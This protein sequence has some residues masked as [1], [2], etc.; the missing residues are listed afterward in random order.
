MNVGWVGGDRA[1]Q[2]RETALRRKKLAARL[3]KSRSAAQGQL[4]LPGEPA[5]NLP[6]TERQGEFSLPVESAVPEK[7]ER[8]SAAADQLV[9]DHPSGER[10]EARV[11][12]IPK[13]A[14]SLDGSAA[15]IH[16]TYQLPPTPAWLKALGQ[17]QRLGLVKVAADIRNAAAMPAGSALVSL[18]WPDPPPSALL[19]WAVSHLGCDAGRDRPLRVLLVGAGRTD[20]RLLSDCMID[21][22]GARP[23]WIPDL[24]RSMNPMRDAMACAF[25]PGRL[26]PGAPDSLRVSSLVPVLHARSDSDRPWVERW[27]GFMQ[28]D[29]AF[30]RSDRG[31]Q[32]GYLRHDYGV[33]RSTRPFAFVLPQ[34]SRGSRR[35]VEIEAIPG[36]VDLVI[37]DYSATWLWPARIAEEVEQLFL[38]VAAAAGRAPV[39][40]FLVLVS[41]PRSR[42]AVLRTVRE[43]QENVRELQGDHASPGQR[44][45]A[46]K[47]YVGNRV[48]HQTSVDRTCIP[49]LRIHAAS[50]T[51]GAIQDEL[52]G[53][54]G[55]LKTSHPKTSEALRQAVTVLSAMATSLA[56]PMADT[57]EPEVMLTFVD[58]ARDARQA[59]QDEGPPA[60]M[61]AIDDALKRGVQAGTKLL[62]N[63]PARVALDEARAAAL[64]GRKVVFVAESD[65]EAKEAAL[66]A[67]EGLL[68]VSR[69]TPGEEIARY[70]PD[71]LVTACRG[72]DALRLLAEQPVPPT[73]VVMLLPP[74]EA[75]TVRRIG[76]LV[77]E[78]SD[79]SPAHGLCKQI[80]DGLPPV[81]SHLAT[82]AELTAGRPRRGRSVSNDGNRAGVRDGVSIRTEDGDIS[83]FASGATLITLVDGLP[84][85]KRAVDL[86]PGDAVIIVPEDVA[87]R[88]IRELGWNSEA[89]LLDVQVLRYKRQVQRWRQGPGAGMT[90][91]QIV[92]LMREADPTVTEPSEAA[93]R[94]WVSAGV[95]EEVAAPRATGNPQ[96]LAAFFKVI[97]LDDADRDFIHFGHHR[98][99]LQREGHLRSGLLERFLFDPYDAFVHH[100]IDRD[101]ARALRETALNSVRVVTWVGLPA[102]ETRQ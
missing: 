26:K 12:A 40:R 16:R 8:G 50:T 44:V 62:R 1:S 73:E 39:P 46:Q 41:D 7:E 59:M 57:E 36:G 102:E 13:V 100:G 11:T 34:V 91:R 49:R 45:S 69:R 87:G 48:G 94:Y 83:E 28:E 19:A 64:R 90:Y 80:V 22:T 53:F 70:V 56:P 93:V 43:L 25:L 98:G 15:T 79:L 81:F 33:A 78:S 61:M 67:P 101:R 63:S 29:R 42:L 51:E 35:T 5:A 14:R 97:G 27:T 95:S 37:A 84:K 82:E 65:S 71:L 47:H 92:G 86:C 60:G 24:G 30:L 20:T 54:A 32:F 52:L 6:D 38:D 66:S 31:G 9:A 76:E 96:W 18:S 88:I 55:E 58:A 21:R 68:I 77:L 10:V 17:E 74:F 2:V 72:A 89:A 99:R 75:M 85:V 4:E 23:F 3:Q